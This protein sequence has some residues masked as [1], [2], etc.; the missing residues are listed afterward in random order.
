M[1]VASFFF[2]IGGFDKAA[3]EMGWTTE[4]ICEWN[5]YGQTIAEEH[6]KEA[7]IYGDIRTTDFSKWRGKIDILCGGFPC[8][9][10]STAGLQLGTEDE[11]HL[12][13]AM[14]RGIR[15][16]QPTWVVGENVR[17]LVSWN[18][19]LVFEQVQADLEAEGYEVL[20]FILPAAGV[21]APHRRHRVFFVAH[22]TDTGSKSLQSGWK[23]G[24]H[25]L[26]TT[27]DSQMSYEQWQGLRKELYEG[28]ARRCDSLQDAAYSNGGRSQGCSNKEKGQFSTYRDAWMQFPT[29]SPVC[30]GDDGFPTELLRQRIREDSLGYLS[31]KEIDQILSKAATK[32]REETIKAAGNAVVPQVVLQIF[33]AIEKYGNTNI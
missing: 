11:R 2:G 17:G 15:E 24:I 9:P 26:E 28:K 14:C 7:T 8:Q 3:K 23:D 29:Q 5:K 10:F 31:E 20:P 6:Y 4:L 33:K 13:P 18:G 19:G 21:N 30:T 32:W 12:W 16:I 22:R 1:R 27:A 25:G